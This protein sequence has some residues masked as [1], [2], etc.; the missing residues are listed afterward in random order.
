MWGLRRSAPVRQPLSSSVAVRPD[1]RPIAH[2]LLVTIRGRPARDTA[3]MP[4]ARLP[5]LLTTTTLAL[6][7]SGNVLGWITHDP[8]SAGGWGGGGTPALAAI[9]VALF[10]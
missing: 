8:Q 1:R 4:V 7:V 9:S 3:R 2:D 5:L 10:T 6:F